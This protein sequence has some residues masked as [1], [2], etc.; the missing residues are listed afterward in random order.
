MTVPAVTTEVVS[1]ALVE[2]FCICCLPQGHEGEHLCGCGGSWT[3][4]DSGVMIPH[5]YP[6]GITFE[7]STKEMSRILT[8]LF[9]WPGDYDYEDDEVDD[10]IDIEID[11]VED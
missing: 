7:E 10:Y 2:T 8:G 4:D 6:G 5:M 3:Y 11:I 9:S 1:C